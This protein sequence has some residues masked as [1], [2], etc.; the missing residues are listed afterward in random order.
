VTAV[1]CR[2]LRARGFGAAPPAGGHGS[3]GDAATAPKPVA[4]WSVQAEV[5]A[6]AEVVT[7]GAP[8][9]SG[10]C[11]RRDASAEPL[12]DAHARRP[13]QAATFRPSLFVQPPPLGELPATLSAGLLPRV[14]SIDL[15]GQ[16]LPPG[17]GAAL[18]ALP[19]LLE[20]QLRSCTLS[21]ADLAGLLHG[22]RAAASPA[23]R[24]SSGSNGAAGGGGG[25]AGLRL[26]GVAD[27]RV[28]SAA[29]EPDPSST[30]VASAVL[31]A[32]LPPTLKTLMAG[33]VRRGMGEA[34]HGLQTSWQLCVKD[35]DCV[36]HPGH[37]RVELPALLK[38]LIPACLTSLPRSSCAPSR[39]R[40]P[41]PSRPAACCCRAASRR[42]CRRFS[43][44]G[45]WGS[46]SSRWI[47]LTGRRSA[48][49]PR[50][51]C[52]GRQRAADLR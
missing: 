3:S 29:G 34:T 44:S 46:R 17:S 24:R 47:R 33:L 49:P 14:A 16:S 52:S 28:V 36:A 2:A 15:S 26:L 51:R 9:G 50:L 25:A 43:S 31:A 23:A 27:L 5:P 12:A 45:A 40:S 10:A 6:A 20:L 22:L 37:V 19:L 42:C 18:G 11:A 39:R 48:G 13:L 41:A 38:H 30:A 4:E 35:V 32:G 7:P 8:A 1:A 21:L